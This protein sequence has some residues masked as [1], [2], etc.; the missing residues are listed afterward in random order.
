MVVAANGVASD[1]VSVQ[2]IQLHV[3]LLHAPPVVYNGAQTVVMYYS[4]T[5]L[6]IVDNNGNQHFVSSSEMSLTQ[7]LLVYFMQLITYIQLH[8][9]L[10]HAPPLVYN[11]IQ[12]VVM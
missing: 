5:P 1:E 6:Y 4:G 8:V 3:R 11:G 10:L 12:A 7:G 9:R 2:L